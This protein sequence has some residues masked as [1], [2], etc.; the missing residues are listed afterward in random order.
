M[1]FTGEMC[2][3]TNKTQT[4]GKQTKA[5]EEMGVVKKKYQKLKEHKLLLHTHW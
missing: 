2:K 1:G 4:Y 3:G 5:L